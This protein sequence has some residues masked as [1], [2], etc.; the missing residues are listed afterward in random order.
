MTARWTGSP[1]GT[2]GVVW[3]APGPLRRCRPR[4]PPPPVPPPPPLWYT[5]T[6]SWRDW[7]AP[8]WS[9]AYHPADAA[10]IST[11]PPARTA[12]SMAF[13]HLAMIR[14]SEKFDNK[15][16]HF[17]AKALSLAYQKGGL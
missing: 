8:A 16:R 13:T 10:M 17:T 14:G 15:R 4:P 1:F 9:Y 12:S 11:M 5:D 3:T 2:T 6:S 7:E